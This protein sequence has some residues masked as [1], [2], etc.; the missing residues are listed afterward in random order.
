MSATLESIRRTI[1]DQLIH[2]GLNAPNDIHG[3]LRALHGADIERYKRTLGALWRKADIAAAMKHQSIMAF[4]SNSLGWKDVF[5]PG[6]DV[7]LLMAN[8]LKIPDGYFGLRA[9]QDYPSV[10]GSLDGLV[11]WTPITNA[12][13]DNFPL[14]VVPGSHRLGLV[15]DVEETR[16]GWQIPESKLNDFQAVEAEAGDVVFMS[17]FTV[18]RSGLEGNGL[19]IALSTRFDNASEST[20]INR[21][22]PTAYQRSVHRE[23]YVKGFPKLEDLAPIWS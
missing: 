16:N 14:E 12:G 18:H 6:G 21:S 8:D 2:L 10:Q 4:L 19:R 17:Y 23:Q 20:Y 5:L 1:A 11:A 9:H 13:S 15:T 7:V 22:Y 3:A